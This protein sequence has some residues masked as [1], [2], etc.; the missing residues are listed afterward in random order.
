[1]RKTYIIFLLTVV[2]SGAGIILY[3]TLKSRDAFSENLIISLSANLEKELASYLDPIREEFGRI[4]ETYSGFTGLQM[5][6]DSLS[7]GIIPVISG[8]PSIG[9]VLIYNDAGYIYAIYRD[10]NTFVSSLDRPGD[11]E[12]GL[13]W[14]RRMSLRLALLSVK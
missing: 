11:P 13:V 10:K 7:S 6:D 2:V 1:M 14:S 5:N 4:T 12:T 9:S 8:V 3:S